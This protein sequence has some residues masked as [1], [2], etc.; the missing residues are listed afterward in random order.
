M[1]DVRRMFM[2][3][4][5]VNLIVVT[6]AAASC[7]CI[8]LPAATGQ[9]DGSN[10]EVGGA[11]GT[12]DDDDLPAS[13]DDVPRERVGG[14]V[15]TGD[16]DDGSIA[17]AQ[18]AAD[19]KITQVEFA[20]PYSLSPLEPYDY[21]VVY[22]GPELRDGRSL[23]VHFSAH[24][25]SEQPFPYLV[26][27]Q[28]GHIVTARP[29]GTINP[30]F[31]T[32]SS[33][34]YTVQGSELGI[35]GI[36][37]GLWALRIPAEL[38][39]AAGQTLGEDVW[40]WFSPSYANPF[41]PLTGI[42][43]A[44]YLPRISGD[45]KRVAVVVAQSTELRSSADGTSATLL[46]LPQMSNLFIGSEQTGGDWLQVTYY[47]TTDESWAK[48]KVS[49]F[50]EL[51][52]LPSIEAVSGYVHRD[53]I[54]EIPEPLNQ[55]TLFQL[56][57]SYQYSLVDTGLRCSAASTLPNSGGYGEPLRVVSQAHIDSMLASCEATAIL[58][59]RPIAGHLYGTPCITAGGERVGFLSPQGHLPQVTWSSEEVTLFW[60]CWE[61]VKTVV[62]GYTDTLKLPDALSEYQEDVIRAFRRHAAAQE[63]WMEWG[64]A[65]AASRAEAPGGEENV[66]GEDAATLDPRVFTDLLADKLDL[67][68]AERQLLWSPFAELD[69]DSAT[70]EE[71]ES[72]Y[73]SM[74]FILDN[75]IIRDSWLAPFNRA[76]EQMRQ[77]G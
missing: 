11:V 16:D 33:V 59:S 36:A 64:L 31:G 15:G 53:D 34:T 10:G 72:A 52:E 27:F 67:T 62:L 65:W 66:V 25:S 20:Y 44:V 23:T 19:L 49:S 28:N 8:L 41:T 42:G 63:A 24:L 75:R 9:A 46:D 77:E 35:A 55:G 13:V 37:Q 1:G 2:R 70:V 58:L 38:L 22:R 71:L 26:L 74:V 39:S 5:W 21:Q 76:N 6:L 43:G 17:E 60:E 69:F 47:Q 48:A 57:L 40:A 32:P 12:G 54:A 56:F 29:P 51:L 30:A 7:G 18:D 50:D 4:V 68:D 73:E 61:H 45:G 3:V 14:A